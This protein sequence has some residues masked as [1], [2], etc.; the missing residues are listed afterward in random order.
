VA[1]ASASLTGVL[2]S[3]VATGACLCIGAGGVAV[4]WACATL[5]TNTNPSNNIFPFIL[6]LLFI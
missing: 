4:S 2:V 5:P 6:I 1:L 3:T